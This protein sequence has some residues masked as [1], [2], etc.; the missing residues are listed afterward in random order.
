MISIVVLTFSF[1]DR[2]RNFKKIYIIHETKKIIKYPS[3]ETKTKLKEN[4]KRND[5]GKSTNKRESR[6]ENQHRLPKTH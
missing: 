4:T 5:I 1:L 3:K 2:K 6:K